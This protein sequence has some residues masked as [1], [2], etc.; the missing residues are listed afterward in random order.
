MPTLLKRIRSAPSDASEAGSRKLNAEPPSGIVL[1]GSTR[2][3][4]ETAVSKEP[5]AKFKKSESY[6]PS[7][8]KAPLI[9][10]ALRHG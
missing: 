7:G 5:L 10:L 6:L 4:S 2:D 9:L 3:T 1:A 8:A